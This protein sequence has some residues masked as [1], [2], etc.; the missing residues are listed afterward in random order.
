MAYPAVLPQHGA[1]HTE[2][3]CKGLAILGVNIVVE[4]G[5]DRHV[6]GPG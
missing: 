4:S 3:L 1:R 6:L 5:S 2:L